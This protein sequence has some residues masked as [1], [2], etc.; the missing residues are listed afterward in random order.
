MKQILLFSCLI[1]GLFCLESGYCDDAGDPGVEKGVC[2]I[3]LHGLGRTKHSM[4]KIENRLK[5]L[6]Y[7]TVNHGY[8]STEQD[9]EALANT[10]VPEAVSCCEKQSAKKIHFITHSLG[11]ILV[12]QY[13]QENSVPEGGRLVMLSPP[14][15]G[16]EIADELK[17]AFFYK[18]VTGPAGQEL[19][20]DDKS[21]PNRLQPIDVEVGVIT[22]NRSFDPWFSPIIPGDDDGKVS[23]GRAR[24]EGMNDFLV[25]ESAHAFIMQNTEVIDQIV[26]FLQEGKFRH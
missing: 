24:L 20:T 11:G 9:I 16:S 1:P 8:P 13:L 14:N 5:A 7:M 15:K 23:V 21:V 6:G 22:G 26:F 19:G 17:D 12:R 2:V 4:A 25:V 18:W 3:L 10:Y